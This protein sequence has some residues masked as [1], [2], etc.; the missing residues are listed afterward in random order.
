MAFVQVRKCVFCGGYFPIGEVSMLRRSGG[1]VC[2]GCKSC[3]AY[4]KQKSEVL[5]K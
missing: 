2:F 5:C 4:H 1:S 3:V